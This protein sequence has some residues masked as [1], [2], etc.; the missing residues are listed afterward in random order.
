MLCLCRCPGNMAV[1]TDPHP[2]RI[3]S[4]SE[5]NIY[6]EKQSREL[7]ALHALNNLFQDHRAFSKSEMDSICYKLS[8]DTYINP[9]KSMFGLGNYD[10]N[11]VMSAL[12]S[13]GYETIWFDKR[14]DIDTLDFE[15][16]C[17]YILNVPTDYKLGMIYLPIHRKHWIALRKIG[18][19]F[20]NLDSKLDG[21]E[22][23]GNATDL[24]AFLHTQV[25]CRNKEL[26]LVVEQDCASNGSWLIS[27]HQH[28]TDTSSPSE[29]QQT[30]NGYPTSDIVSH[31]HQIHVAEKS[32]KQ[33]TMN[34]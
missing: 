20:Y 18:S 32:S 25:A 16:I 30:Q 17:G 4:C 14:K 10:V 28:Q 33:D 6:H 8:P 13:K 26:L 34:R 22:V 24:R 11:V 2:H 3:T 27:K 15:N 23:I 19:R 5:H 1:R 21:P 9:H 7:C 12:Q 29:N 31:P